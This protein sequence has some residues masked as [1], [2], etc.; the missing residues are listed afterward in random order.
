MNILTLSWPVTAV[1]GRIGTRHDRTS[2]G[3]VFN[4]GLSMAYLAHQT[5][6]P[7]DEPEVSR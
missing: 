2:Q 6:S 1:P 5:K 3:N 7:M 4:P